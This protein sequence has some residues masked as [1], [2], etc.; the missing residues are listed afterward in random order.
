MGVWKKVSS[1]FFFFFL[2]FVIYGRIIDMGLAKKKRL[3]CSHLCNKIIIGMDL[4]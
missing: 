4:K 1:A 3:L 2:F